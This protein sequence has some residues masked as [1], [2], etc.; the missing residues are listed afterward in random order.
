[1]A[2]A[3]VTQP[4]VTGPAFRTEQVEAASATTR[5]AEQQPPPVAD[6]VT[7]HVLAARSLGDGIRETVLHLTPDNLGA[8]TVTLQVQGSDVRLDLAAN[9]A[10][11]DALDAGIGDLRAELSASGLDL[12][13]V[14]LRP[15]DG[16]QQNQGRAPGQEGPG[17]GRQDG[18]PAPGGDGRTSESRPE[19]RTG[20][21]GTETDPG[22]GRSPTTGPEPGPRAP[23]DIRV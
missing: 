5:S 2:A 6:Q 16:G 13:D 21:T 9:Q 17:D 11:L 4:G 8:V 20:V 18:R 19:R 10:A 22:P 12:T 3:A 15:D 14:T 1:V 7:R 23:L